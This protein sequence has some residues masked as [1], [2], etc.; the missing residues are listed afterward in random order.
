MS[1]LEWHARQGSPR[2]RTFGRRS[3]RRLW[4][5]LMGGAFVSGIVVGVHTFRT[6]SRPTRELVVGV[7]SPPVLVVEW[8]DFSLFD[9]NAPDSLA[10]L[11]EKV[12]EETLFSLVR[13]LRKTAEESTVALYPAEGGAHHYVGLVRLR[14]LARLSLLPMWILRPSEGRYRGF[15]L[16]RWAKKPQEVHMALSGRLVLL[17]DSR[18]ALERTLDGVRDGSGGFLLQM[19]SPEGKLRWTRLQGQ[20]PE[21]V[22]SFYGRPHPGEGSSS[23]WYGEIRR[24]GH[25]WNADVWVRTPVTAPSADAIL[26]AR[27]L[28]LRTPASGRATLWHSALSWQWLVENVA[29]PL[30]IGW[31]KR[32]TATLSGEE[33][34][35]PMAL[36]IGQASDKLLPE[37]VV[38]FGTRDAE[39][40]HQDLRRRRIRLSV[41]R[42]GATVDRDGKVL[43]VPLTPTLSYEAGIG[44]LP[45]AFVIA[46]SPEAAERATG[47]PERTFAAMIPE[48]SHL[49]DL[50]YLRSRPAALAEE[51]KRIVE[52]LRVATRVRER[53][54]SPEKT[55]VLAKWADLCALF[56]TFDVD[57]LT[58][59]D[60]YRLFV[61]ATLLTPPGK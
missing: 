56:E 20:S 5:I 48:T 29:A 18:G 44:A 1:V 49:A 55:E 60:G 43:S 40:L 11:L 3:R 21:R 38:L 58:T 42:E 37:F 36:G 50:F 47:K 31:E 57:A 13:F 51:M 24:E 9:R 17:S 28:V 22:G 14:P 27:T 16:I 12:K 30:G 41:G 2:R 10:P 4:Y 54:T 34:H 33:T 39:R 59:P 53:P 7:P 32:E 46:S 61:R 26:A 25:T 8:R 45:E 35:L 6:P 15:R 23:E 19:P 52:L